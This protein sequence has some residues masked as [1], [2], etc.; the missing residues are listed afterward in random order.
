MS[1]ILQTPQGEHALFLHPDRPAADRAQVLASL[2]AWFVDQ[3]VQFFATARAFEED[4][5]GVGSSAADLGTTSRRTAARS[6][7]PASLQ[8]RSPAS[9][10]PQAAAAQVAAG[11]PFAS[12]LRPAPGRRPRA[13][14]CC[15]PSSPSCRRRRPRAPAAGHGL[16]PITDTALRARC[17]SPR[18]HRRPSPRRRPTW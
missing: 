18:G 15:R 13:A 2:P 16:A 7:R 12:W 9:P 3:Q 17:R 4:L 11:T 5:A 14:T 8:R 1:E 6:T 10:Q